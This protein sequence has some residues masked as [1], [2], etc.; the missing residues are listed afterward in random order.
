MFF[1]NKTTIP[2]VGSAKKTGEEDEIYI[3]S[4][5]CVEFCYHGRKYNKIKPPERRILQGMLL[6][7]YTSFPFSMNP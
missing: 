4:P 3:N 6:F 7:C 2:F 1:K 5:A